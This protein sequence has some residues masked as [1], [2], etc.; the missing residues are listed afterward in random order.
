MTDSPQTTAAAR[1][2]MRKLYRPL[3]ARCS[4]NA[5]HMLVRGQ[6]IGGVFC[7]RHASATGKQ[8]NWS[9][10]VDFDSSLPEQPSLEPTRTVPSG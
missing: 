2:V 5:T 1:W 8:W 7:W 6:E 4:A 10:V 3:C 9:G